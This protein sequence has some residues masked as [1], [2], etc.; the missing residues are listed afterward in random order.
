[1]FFN[2]FHVLL[3]LLLTFHMA[4]AFKKVNIDHELNTYSF[5]YQTDNKS[6]KILIS[7]SVGNNSYSLPTFLKTLETL[8]CGKDTAAKCHLWVIFDRST[9]KSNEIF[10]FWLENTRLLFDTISM[11][12]TQNDLKT[13]EQHVS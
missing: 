13:K 1:M 10:L 12:K 5:E 9:D 4:Y 7:I 8:K 6:S 11:V 3:C 2:P